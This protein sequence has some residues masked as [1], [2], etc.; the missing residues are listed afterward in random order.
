MFIAAVDLACLQTEMWVSPLILHICEESMK[1]KQE[2]YNCPSNIVLA[3][4]AVAL[5]DCRLNSNLL[6]FLCREIC[7]TS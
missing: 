6:I 1:E 4:M 2:L 7:N 5:G 3:L